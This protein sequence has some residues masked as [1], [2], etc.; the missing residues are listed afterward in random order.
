MGSPSLSH[1]PEETRL[2]RARPVLSGTAAF[3]EDRLGQGNEME[4]KAQV[5]TW[6]VALQRSLPGASQKVEVFAGMDRDTNRLLVGQTQ[7]VCPL[8]TDRLICGWKRN[9]KTNEQVQPLE[10]G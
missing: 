8:Q 5:L 10:K 4:D 2:S 3:A 7:L 9:R 6:C 1:A